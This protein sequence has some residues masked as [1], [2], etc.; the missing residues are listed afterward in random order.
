M[1]Q[2]VLVTGGA[3]FIGGHVAE[4]LLQRGDRVIAYDNLDP[5][6]DPALKLRNIE[7]LSQ[8]E[9]FSFVEG[10]IRSPE[11]L[12]SVRRVDSV[13][14]L[15][16]RAGVRPSIEE[17]AL[18]ADVNLTGTTHVLDFA[19]R[20]QVRSFV[21]ASSS[22]V[23]GERGNP[24]FSESE[25]VNFPASPYAATKRSGELL[26][27]SYNQVF[28]M[29]ITCLRFFTVY[30]PRQRPEMAMA[31]FTSCIAQGEPIQL[32]G[33]G[34][35]QR[36]FTYV[37]DAVAGILAALNRTDGYDIFNIGHRRMTSVIDVIHMLADAIGAPPELEILPPQPGDVSLTCAD[38][39]HAH[40][41]LGYNP[42]VPIEDG[43]ARYVDWYQKA[44]V[45]AH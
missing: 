14:H 4:A 19:K 45:L 20:H 24:P 23:Y 17:A 25:P 30:G 15:A 13:V 11:Q 34:S 2:R 42:A 40:S 31:R 6:Y 10:D 1:S 35:A 16:A 32:Y 12:A 27:A 28:D 36:D 26:C 5:Y 9:G 37:T 22:S 7:L 29:P 41:V 39:E 44:E 21:F 43:I 33:D 38:I 3:G 18:Y 8:Y